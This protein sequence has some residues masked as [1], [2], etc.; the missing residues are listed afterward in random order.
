MK[1]SRLFQPRNPLFWMMLALN[2]LSMALGWL[3]QNRPLNALGMAIVLVF[4][5]ANAVLG[6]WLAWRLTQRI[7]CRAGEKASAR[8]GRPAGELAPGH[9]TLCGQLQIVGPACRRI[10]DAAPAAMA[11]ASDE[12]A[13]H[14]PVLLS[15][16]AR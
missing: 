16:S 9:V 3:V 8:L 1:L 11:R 12:A 10:Q 15:E 7:A 4:A 6:M 2:G 5:L 14:S 13:P